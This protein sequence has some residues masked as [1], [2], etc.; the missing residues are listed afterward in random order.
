MQGSAG[1]GEEMSCM[2]MLVFLM[3]LT[4]LEAKSIPAEQV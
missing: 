4:E 1:V 2:Q 3:T